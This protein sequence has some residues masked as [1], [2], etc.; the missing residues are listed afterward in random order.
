[1]RLWL[2]LCLLVEAVVGVPQ[3]NGAMF[4]PTFLNPG[5]E[6]TANVPAGA[7]G[8]QGETGG[9][10]V[11]TGGITDTLGG[12]FAAGNGAC[13]CTA[14]N[15]NGAAAAVAN[16]GNVCSCGGTGMVD[17]AAIQFNYGVG[18]PN[19]DLDMRFET[20]AAARAITTPHTMT[21]QCFL[22]NDL[23]VNSAVP[24][25][26]TLVV[27]PQ[28]NQGPGITVNTPRVVIPEDNSAVPR[29][30][31]QTCGLSIN[32]AVTVTAGPVWERQPNVPDGGRGDE[33]SLVGCNVVAAASQCSAIGGNCV[34][35]LALTNVGP[36]TAFTANLNYCIEQDAVG[37]ISVQ[38]DF[39]DTS[40]LCCRDA[41]A[42]KC[43]AALATFCTGQ[44]PIV[45]SATFTIVIEEVNDVP[46]GYF[47]LTSVAP[48]LVGP[49]IW[50][51]DCGLSGYTE[52]CRNPTAVR[53][54]HPWLAIQTTNMNCPATST[55]IPIDGGIT[56]YNPCTAGGAINA[57]SNTEVQ[58]PSTAVSE[59]T[60]GPGVTGGQQRW[61]MRC[62][63]NEDHLFL[64]G[65]AGCPGC[66]GAVPCGCPDLGAHPF[67]GGLQWEPA[68]HAVGRANIMCYLE[69][70]NPVAAG[71][72]VNNRG[73]GQ[74]NNM[75]GTT[76]NEGGVRRRMLI[77]FTIEITEVNDPPSI[78]LN[79]EIVSTPAALA[80]AP[81]L[82]DRLPRVLFRKDPSWTGPTLDIWTGPNPAD[83]DPG[84]CT[85]VDCCIDDDLASVV[86][87]TG[88]EATPANMPGSTASI[89]MQNCPAA[90]RAKCCVIDNVWVTG[91]A[92]I[93]CGARITAAAC[94]QVPAGCSWTGTLCI[95]RGYGDPATS[96]TFTPNWQGHVGA[97]PGPT[98]E[99][100]PFNDALYMWD[101][102]WNVKCKTK[103]EP[104]NKPASFYGPGVCDETMFDG[105][106]VPSTFSSA[107]YD[108]GTHTACP[109][110]IWPLRRS[111]NHQL[112]FRASS[113]TSNSHKYKRGT[114]RI[115]CTQVDEGQ[116]DGGTACP[117]PAPTTNFG[118]YIS[119]CRDAATFPGTAPACIGTGA[120]GVSPTGFACPSQEVQDDLIRLPDPIEFI[121]EF[122]APNYTL[123]DYPTSEFDGVKNPWWE[124]QVPEDSDPQIITNYLKDPQV[125]A[126]G[127]AV[128]NM[129]GTITTE[130]YDTALFHSNPVV[131][132][133]LPPD[134][135]DLHFTSATHMSGHTWVV[136]GLSDDGAGVP[137][138]V[139]GPSY[140][141]FVLWITEV[142]DPPIATL[143]PAVAPSGK[144]VVDEDTNLVTGHSML[145]IPDLAP[146]PQREVD[147]MPGTGGC[148]LTNTFP[149]CGLIPINVADATAVNWN[150]ANPLCAN[151]CG[152]GA[153]CGCGQQL[154][155]DCNV[156]MPTMF[157]TLPA[158]AATGA[159][160]GTLTF[161]LKPDAAGEALVTCA[162]K[163]CVDVGGVPCTKTTD[164]E[165]ALT[166]VV[167]F[168][169]VVNE[170][171]DPP[172]IE[173]ITPG[174]QVIVD[175]DS[176]VHTATVLVNI[177]PGPESERLTQ[178]VDVTCT[179]KLGSSTLFS[180]PVVTSLSG[181]TTGLQQGQITFTPAPDAAGTAAVNCQASDD[182][183]PLKTTSVASFEIIIREVNDP[184]T[185]T[186]LM[187]RV[188]VAED[189]GTYNTKI[190][191]NLIPGPL[192]EQ[193]IP[194]TLTITCTPGQANLFATGPTISVN[195][196]LTF[197]PAVD[198]VGSTIVQCVFVDDGMPP[199][200]WSTTFEI[201]ITEVNDP[202][203]V[204]VNGVMMSPT[205]T[206]Q[207]DVG[208]VEASNFLTGLAPG[209]P[210]EQASQS[211]SF[212]CVVDRPELFTQRPSIQTVGTT[213]T[214]I[215]VTAP[216][217]AGRTTASCLMT[218]TGVPV[219]TQSF[220]FDI[221]IDEVNDPPVATVTENPVVVTEDTPPVVRQNFLQ[222]LSPGPPSESS[223]S[224]VIVC[225]SD[226][227][228]FAVQPRIDTSG[229]LLFTPQADTSGSTGVDCTLTDNGIPPKQT[230]I[231][232]IIEVTEVNDPPLVLQ[233][234]DRVRVDE[235]T[236][237][238]IFNSHWQ[239]LAAGPPLEVLAGQTFTYS[240]S[241]TNS[242]MFVTGGQ[243]TVTVMGSAARL[244]FEAG[245][246][247]AGESLVSC[248]LIDNG[249]PSATTHVEFTIEVI[250]L[251]DLPTATCDMCDMGV[252]VPEDNGPYAGDN[253]LTMISPGPA[254][255]AMQTITIVCTASGNPNLWLK[256]TTTTPPLDG[257]PKI[258]PISGQLTFTPAADE[259]GVSLVSCAM[260]DNGT[261][262]STTNI[263]PF[264]V[265][266]T[267]VNDKPTGVVHPSGRASVAVG[268]TSTVI[269]DW[270]TGIT[271]GPPQE[272]TQ[273]VS[274]T[275]TADT[276][277]L[278]ATAGQPQ[279]DR[280]TG[281]LSF[282]PSTVNSEGASLVSCE[283]LDNGSPPETL[284]VTFT[285]AM[286]NQPPTAD[287]SQA[288][289]TIDEESG[290]YTRA[291][292]LVN[293]APGPAVEV[294]SGQSIATITCTPADTTLF[295]V[296]PVISTIGTLEF[297]PG[298]DAAGQ[299]RVDCTVSDNGIPQRS[300]DVNFTISITD[301][302]DP[303][304][305]V[306]NQ[307]T[308][309][310]R[311]NSDA[312]VIN[313]FISV[314][315]GPTSELG[316]VLS[317]SCMVDDPTLLSAGPLLNLAG[318]STTNQ[319][320]VLEFTPSTDKSGVTKATCVIS[321]NGS[322]S[323]SNT[324]T[325]DISVTEQNDPPTATVSQ[326]FVTVS[327]G[328]S[329]Y[330]L[331]SFLTGITP[332]PPAE[333]ARG[334]TVS[335][336]CVPM[337]A[338][339]FTS[340]GRP[341]INSRGDLS[342]VPAPNAVGSS[343]VTCT[344]TD[345]GNPPQSITVQFTVQ[346]TEVNN[347]PIATLSMNSVTIDEDSGAAAFPRFVNP[348]SPG[349]P[350]EASQVIV[351]TCTTGQP[352]LF[353]TPVSIASFGSQIGELTFTPAAD[354]V[355]A[356]EV[357][358][359]VQD[360][361][362][363]PL[364]T[365]FKFS[366]TIN[367]VNDAPS[368]LLKSNVATVT[369]DGGPFVSTAFVYQIEAG[370][371]SESGQSVAITCTAEDVSLFTIQPTVSSSGNLAFTPSG[372]RSG[373][374]K[375]SCS[376]I[377]NG[378]PPAATNIA[379]TVNVIDSNDPP[380]GTLKQTVIMIQE[381][382]DTV[383]IQDFITGLAAGPQSEVDAGQKVIVE[384]VPE[385]PAMFETPP[386]ID[387]S[388]VLVGRLTFKIAA[389]AV[390]ATD[391][392]CTA[393][394][395][396]VPPA[397]RVMTF[398]VDV[399]EVNDPPVISIPDQNRNVPVYQ[400]VTDRQ[401]S[402]PQFMT[403]NP[404]PSSEGTQSV[405][406]S[407][408]AT[409]P[410]LFATLPSVQ[411]VNNVA[412]LSFVAKSGLSQA[413]A[414]TSNVV[415]TFTDNGV[416]AMSST[417]NFV[418]DFNLPKAPGLLDTYRASP[419]YEHSPLYKDLAPQAQYERT[420]EYQDSPAGKGDTPL[421]QWWGTDVGRQSPSYKDAFP[422]SVGQ[423][424][425]LRMRLNQLKANF[426]LS[427]FRSAVQRAISNRVVTSVTVFWVCPGEACPVMECP[428]TASRR[429][430][431]QCGLGNEYLGTSREGH[432][433]QAGTTVVDFD[434]KMSPIPADNGK[435]QEA[436]LQEARQAL[437]ASL[438]TAGSPLGDVNAAETN[439]KLCGECD[440][441][442]RPVS[443][444]DDSGFKWWWHGFAVLLGGL[445]LLCLLLALCCLCCRG[446]K[447]DE[448]NQTA[449]K[450]TYQ[451]SDSK[452]M[453]SVAPGG[454]Y[455]KDRYSQYPP[456][457]SYHESDETGY[458]DAPP[459][460]PI[461]TL[462]PSH[463][464]PRPPP[465]KPNEEWQPYT[466]D[467]GDAGYEDPRPETQ[468]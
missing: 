430:E 146:G 346:I 267:E 155:V 283:L 72:L 401:Y 118:T 398:S 82:V 201:E 233:A 420:P 35:N 467:W 466:V 247:Q 108:V 236:G 214:V 273:T 222:P 361:G 290:P 61:A 162:A 406:S 189:S 435:S 187:P 443:S 411:I 342:L 434:V 454:D 355:G 45:R 132:N 423:T 11:F 302:N 327:E 429:F 338:S 70:I 102:Q 24:F 396:V 242:A 143:N 288:V 295:S 114:V 212:S 47:D 328:T 31:G 380:V 181:S 198:A 191:D 32:N 391:V 330:E 225:T 95:T 13:T 445:C 339:L 30:V 203:Q 331:P 239:G 173:L 324:I 100:G 238:H 12:T 227:T 326:T 141:E 455:P 115:Q 377:D 148:P 28:V 266:V 190:V 418:I 229:A 19:F 262:I 26:M 383:T 433:L 301:V 71:L 99:Q 93:N 254:S 468:Y 372:D 10:R 320:G 74:T 46:V 205:I 85:V 281:D 425:V 110:A 457:S 384:C 104:G 319:F 90:R 364:V 246:D 440:V 54:N 138:N 125:W 52:S 268:T 170:I 379:F 86:T 217:A 65:N 282:T 117:A 202:P 193:L 385:K 460:N 36:A 404:G 17:L 300:T 249:L 450:E 171:N 144:V 25:D 449:P 51:E 63:T 451:E 131:A 381:D 167:T 402:F 197:T 29:S 240:C 344:V 307:M 105:A 465:E 178:N 7:A 57:L 427:T 276:P 87:V 184:P 80:A 333:V 461:D 286:E 260:S 314:T 123:S 159:N 285:V 22:T 88:L 416:P 49:H 136:V 303:P 164:G 59:W 280:A 38:C 252:T 309:T 106:V 325:F 394:D 76:V 111:L 311:E 169:I 431:L 42:R 83:P 366:V 378:S 270:I 318:W 316:Q 41:N 448:E 188:T 442:T 297:T 199:L 356:T 284:I 40:Q 352:A 371:S 464:P 293:L 243:P 220:T 194:Q 332:G 253:F 312:V 370:P 399:A 119:G 204:T 230:T 18:P 196:I 94:Q 438:G 422:G 305:V 272:S 56:V 458:N 200:S 323:Q 127:A 213:G 360:N 179:V 156:N 400:D 3:F 410:H 9:T 424:T 69:D 4:T 37:I 350:S 343:E 264:T 33:V 235:D 376:M 403:V 369:E 397:T 358:C 407:C 315:P 91:N 226:P 390:G 122:T 265:T 77:Q 251:N 177:S 97:L 237:A 89:A 395:D 157:D 142:N 66:G 84:V 161:R 151:T 313:E 221:V 335:I 175:E 374:T 409:N 109:N 20:V 207:E 453:T 6:I 139:N 441:T 64:N 296:S 389:N 392:V 345:T 73:G 133:L 463:S 386:A 426:K 206:V 211:F 165:D 291:S 417:Q 8:A 182:G 2:A 271:P 244:T 223:Q 299:T 5:L 310:A 322:P 419:E 351:T 308:V 250:D 218:D 231:A 210:S 163:D 414:L 154:Q 306:L 192:S 387:T 274:I 255:E 362:V 103:C 39:T 462:Y 53:P 219:K 75:G 259:S 348:L 382:A 368:A 166:T 34:S 153:G 68:M 261:P 50:Q 195:G 256:D 96:G 415:C 135:G 388:S 298:V 437:D 317:S 16:G 58:A 347:P 234:S 413:T 432:V 304:N 258:D 185:G 62:V 14:C 341:S 393:R 107:C 134:G 23:N 245:P 321:D 446:D 228:F 174:L 126:T 359:R 408:T 183:T 101:Q 78:D 216:D 412:N 436:L 337:D 208:R 349:P 232:F 287:V 92:L 158:V 137:A 248:D 124:V 277:S 340:A 257:S 140:E 121:I 279:V 353:V 186:L 375:V 129:K 334:E 329:L 209:P 27:Y 357:T 149:G 21:L 152:T 405:E 459:T 336:S 67:N 55:V 421:S 150:M 176:P 452:E 60:G 215:F 224:L 79:P 116:P 44:V 180:G 367:E 292:Y 373:S 172:T 98:S 43:P 160:K 365:T 128:E 113:K 120:P 354:A 48:S 263:K 439:L 147:P 278:F 447:S 456:S 15:I 275:C 81:D 1:M 168:S 294:S 289:V 112:V 444:D 145:L 130:S 241:H 428:V 363:P 269:Q